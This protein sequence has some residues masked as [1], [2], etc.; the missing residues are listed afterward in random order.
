MISWESV[1][2]TP[3]VVNVGGWGDLSGEY[4]KPAVPT[5]KGANLSP[6]LA[7]RKEFLFYNYAYFPTHQTPC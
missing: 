1:M 5:N 2:L 3:Y 4:N 7:V 6:P